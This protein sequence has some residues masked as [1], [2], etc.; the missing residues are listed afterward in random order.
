MELF[1]F[2]KI[3]SIESAWWWCVWP[4]EGI[5]ERPH[6]NKQANNFDTIY[7]TMQVLQRQRKGAH[8]NTSG[9]FYIYAEYINSNHLNDDKTIFPNKIFDTILKPHNP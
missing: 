6:L 7:N 4:L 8:L 3:G 9:R 5:S 2:L 1:C